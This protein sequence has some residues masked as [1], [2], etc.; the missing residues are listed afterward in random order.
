MTKFFF[1]IYK[2]IVI[3]LPLC[4]VFIKKNIFAL[5]RYLTVDSGLC[6]DLNFD[7]LQLEISFSDEYK[8]IIV[9]SCLS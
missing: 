3:F 6:L 1:L 2:I 5:T 8:S 9:I 4:L 7:C